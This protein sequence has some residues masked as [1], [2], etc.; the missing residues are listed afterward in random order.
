LP[1]DACSITTGI[2]DDDASAHAG[3]ISPT[4]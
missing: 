2:T 4:R 3:T 1:D